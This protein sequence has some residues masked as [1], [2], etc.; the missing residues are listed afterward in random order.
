MI[1][2]ATCHNCRIFW[3]A[4]PKCKPGQREKR[5]R[6]AAGQWQ[7]MTGKPRDYSFFSVEARVVESCFAFEPEV[8]GST[9]DDDNL[10]LASLHENLPQTRVFR[11][12]WL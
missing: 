12:A 3:K 2:C 5:V 7:T 4:T 6:C 8:E 9:I 11:E 10:F 1:A